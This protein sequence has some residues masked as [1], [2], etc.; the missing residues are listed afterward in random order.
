MTVYLKFIVQVVVTIALVIVAGLADDRLDLIEWINAGIAGL[1]AI[2]V[3]GAGNLPSGVW[4]YTKSIVA[5]AT[6]LLVFLVSALS[7]GH[8]SNSEWVQSL[9]A[10]AGAIGVYAVKGPRVYDALSVGRIGGTHQGPAA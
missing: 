1:G 2:S 10:V 8:I 7:D 9:I 5:A 4:A 6:A 3:L